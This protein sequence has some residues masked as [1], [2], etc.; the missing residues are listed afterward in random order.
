MANFQDFLRSNL[1]ILA[2]HL[3]IFLEHLDDENPFGKFLRALVNQRTK[4]VNG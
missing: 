4:S 2:N 3:V 1:V